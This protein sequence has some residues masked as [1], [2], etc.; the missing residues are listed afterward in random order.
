[1]VWYG[2]AVALDSFLLG[3]LQEEGVLAGQQ[4]L[5]R[6]IFGPEI[7]EGLFYSV[8]RPR[9]GF[10]HRRV[11]ELALH[12]AHLSGQLTLLCELLP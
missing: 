6:V 5:H 9:L 3:L 12:P 8:L 7:V 2:D 10:G 4:P 1:M 11:E